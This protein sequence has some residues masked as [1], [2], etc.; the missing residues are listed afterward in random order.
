VLRR[1]F[2][3]VVLARVWAAYLCLGISFFVFGAGTLNIVY[4]LR[5]NTELL[6]NYGWQAVMDGGLRQLVELLV[7]GYVAMAAYLVFKACEY[8][9]VHWLKEEPAPVLKQEEPEE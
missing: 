5:A 2:H 8:R 9:L 6:W 4:L 3:R 1:W 7:T